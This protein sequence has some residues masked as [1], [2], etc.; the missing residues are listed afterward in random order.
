MKKAIFRA[1]GRQLRAAAGEYITVNRIAGEIG[2]EHTF[3]EVL[4]IES[5]SKI[6]LGSPYV[7]GAVVR[8]ELVENMRGPKLRV[9][10]MRRRKKSRSLLGF[11]SEL[12]KLRITA[13]GKG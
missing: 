12:S 13:V 5:G 10:R 7:E 6:T 8:A 4:A 11:R 9:L 1:Q 2:S 3:S